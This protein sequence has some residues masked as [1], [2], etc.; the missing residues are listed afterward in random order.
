METIKIKASK[1]NKVK[2]FNGFNTLFLINLKRLIRNKAVLSTAII[3]III[4]FIFSSTT[5][6][7]LKTPFNAINMGVIFVSISFI[8]E[9]FFFIVFMVIISTELIKKQM[10]DGIQNIETRSGI[11][12]QKS[13]LL[14]W[15]VFITFVGGV[16]AIN[17]IIKII[18][19]SSIVLKFDLVSGIILSNCIFYFFLTIAWS[20][21]VFLVT[22][23]CSIAWSVML[24]IMIAMILCLSSMFTSIP[25]IIEY[26]KPI[27]NISVMK[28][29]LKINIS[30]SFYETFK[31]DEAVNSIF[32]DSVDTKNNS[33]FLSEVQNNLNIE[34]LNAQDINYYKLSK[35]GKEEGQTYNT[36]MAA[37][38]GG[39]PSIYFQEDEE[40]ETDEIKPIPVLKNTEIFKILDEIYQTIYQGMKS[41]N[42]KPTISSPGYQ[43]SYIDFNNRSESEFHNLS[44]L[45]K[46]LKKQETTKKYSSL[47]NWTNSIYSKYIFALSATRN[48][49]DDSTYVFASN[50][51]HLS[52][53]ISNND[54]EENDEIYKVYLR[55]P[56]LLIINNIITE[57]WLNNMF[58][59]GELY[60]A[61]WTSG[62][63]EDGNMF[64][65]PYEAYDAYQKWTNES[66][67][68]NNIN[69]FQHF[70]SMHSQLF[71]SS[72]NKDLMFSASVLSYTG[73]TTGYSNY[74]DL[75]KYDLRENKG[76]EPLS[77][78][79]SKVN[80]KKKISY[81]VPV[82]YMIYLLLSF[83]LNYLAYIIWSRKSKI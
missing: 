76:N 3:S 43:G 58:W 75:A 72:L 11:K 12:F 66:I 50:F 47:L 23:I 1:I 71:G 62:S 25:S 30:K 21:I 44:P 51:S 19:S 65:T 24:N 28:T 7:F 54:I 68:K 16:A 63:A 64:K 42:N 83:G 55:Y 78:I 2:D 67:L 82:I 33:I 57:A 53:S 17:S 73:I 34:T 15:F 29:N 77:P 22:I 74:T 13:F 45:I 18:I 27:N 20:P 36:L 39:A 32:V 40:I 79:F 9:V 35:L 38:Y 69:I 48:L 52:T 6:G 56:E 59:R 10:Q 4:T 80:L 61:D 70:S 26:S 37:L 8:C 41:D 46:W 14:R 31:D 81:N 60:N 5:A 49:F